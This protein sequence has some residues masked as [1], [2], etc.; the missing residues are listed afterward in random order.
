M[1]DDSQYELTGEWWTA[2]CDG[3]DGTLVMVTCREDIG[4]FRDNPRFSIRITISWRYSDNGMPDTETAA[5]MGC[6]TSQLGRAFDKDPVA[7]LT[8]IYTGEGE[9]T[10]V[11]YTLS[12]HIFGRKLN[13]SLSEL[14][15]LPLSISAENDPEWSEY[16]EVSSMK[17]DF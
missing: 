9:R 2:P 3:N 7:V 10:W 14:P 13:E 1:K 12:T 4:R 6:V 16:A 11:F 17:P 5:L 15:L 8:G